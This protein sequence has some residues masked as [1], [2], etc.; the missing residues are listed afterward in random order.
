LA[1][2]IPIATLA[3]GAR[4]PVFTGNVYDHLGGAQTL[5]IAGA[6]GASTEELFFREVTS[7]ANLRRR[8]DALSFE[9]DDAHT[10]GE[11]IEIDLTVLALITLRGHVSPVRSYRVLSGRIARVRI[12]DQR[13]TWIRVL[14]QDIAR[15][16]IF[17]RYI[18]RPGIFL[19]DL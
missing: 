2:T 4:I 17:T 13:I 7:R 10:G 15:H 11:R 9:T 12:L 8:L 5:A 1:Y 19:R 18:D 6:D 3:C 16:R 14:D